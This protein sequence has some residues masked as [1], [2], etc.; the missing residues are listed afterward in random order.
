ML[1]V[2]SSSDQD[3]VMRRIRE[4]TGATVQSFVGDRE[5]GQSSYRE[6]DTR[7]I[8]GNGG[9]VTWHLAANGRHTVRVFD[10]LGRRMAELSFERGA[11]ARD[12]FEHPFARSDVP[13]VFART[14]DERES[15]SVA[16][17][18]VTGQPV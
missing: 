1:D 6:I 9:E 2:R 4:Q 13:D 7:K 15:P 5:R 3:W 16:I 11:E 8:A 17:D 12:A 18:L 10:N 14:D